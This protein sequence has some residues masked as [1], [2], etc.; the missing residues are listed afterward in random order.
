LRVLDTKPIGEKKKSLLWYQ[1]FFA[2]RFA[3]LI[4]HPLVQVIA[5]LS[6]IAYALA[7]I[8]GLSQLKV[9]FDLM[10]IATANSSTHRFLE[11]R[12]RYFV[13][14]LSQLDLAVL[15]PPNMGNKTER[16]VF[17]E[18][19]HKFE[20]TPCSAGRKQTGFWFFAYK[21]YLNEMGFGEFV[22]DAAVD[23]S[24]SEDIIM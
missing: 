13:E 22:E 24:V 8:I 19:L 16:R 6:F 9:G 12:S 21:R 2:Q 15:N 17:L 20:S 10:N 7:T 3:S 1:E 4:S 23:Y 11:M 14:D 5:L 18:E